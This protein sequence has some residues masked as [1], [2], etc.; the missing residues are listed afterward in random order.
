ML[1]AQWYGGCKIWNGFAKFP[2]PNYIVSVYE[3]RRLQWFKHPFRSEM[4]W[5]MGLM[6]SY[7]SNATW[8]PVKKT[9]GRWKRDNARKTSEMAYHSQSAEKSRSRLACMLRRTICFCLVNFWRDLKVATYINEDVTPKNN[10]SKTLSTGL[11]E[12]IIPV[13]QSC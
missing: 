2:Y 1:Y 10:G 8:R 4:C 9:L 3:K 12:G 5:T 13:R 7:R 11:N 6:W